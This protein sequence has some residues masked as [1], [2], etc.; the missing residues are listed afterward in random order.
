MCITNEE[1]SWYLLDGE[2]AWIVGGKEIIAKQ[3]SFIHLP[4][5]LPH[6]FA[7]KSHKPAQMIT[8]YAP[9]GFKNW[10]LEIGTPAVDLQELTPP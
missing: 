4:R 2:M 6:T 9:A 3:G 1:E 8:T 5:L 7:N 10:F